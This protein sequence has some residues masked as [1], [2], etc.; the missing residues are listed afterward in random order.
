MEEY[1]ECPICLDIFGATQNHIRSPKVLKCGDSICKECLEKIIQTD[2]NVFLCPICKDEIKKEENIND[3]TTNKE[4]IRII[5]ASFNIPKNE[6]ENQEEEPPTS[7]NIVLL[8]NSNVGKSSIFQ[9]LSKDIFTEHHS[10]TV[11]IDVVTYYIKFKMKKYKL[12]IH[13]SAGQE[14]YKSI[15]KSI[16]RHK[17]GVLFIYDISNQESFKD[18]KTWYELYKNE[19]EGVIGLIIGNKCDIERKVNKEKAKK[20]ALEHKLKYIETSAKL[21][22]NVRKAIA[23]LLDLI[24]KSKK[25]KIIKKKNEQEKNEECEKTQYFN[26]NETYSTVMSK[27]SK[28]KCNC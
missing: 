8:G 20:F 24:I 5:N 9:R 15:T 1:P 25:S 6:V 11:G 23:C 7:Y 2:E 22:K 4:I 12:I 14:R 28:K 17:D 16:L 27:D 21:D 18:L 3:Y 13:D 10:T 19:N 26:L